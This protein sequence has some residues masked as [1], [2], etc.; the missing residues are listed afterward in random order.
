MIKALCISAWAVAAAASGPATA[1]DYT[2]DEGLA[3][4]SRTQM[5]NPA[6]VDRST[7]TVGSCAVDG[8]E[9]TVNQARLPVS[10]VD[11]RTAYR[12]FTNAIDR[13]TAVE[14]PAAAGGKLYGATRTERYHFEGMRQSNG[15]FALAPASEG[16]CLKATVSVL[17]T[18][19]SDPRVAACFREYDQVVQRHEEEHVEDEIAL[20]K[21]LAADARK[22][23]SATSEGEM[24]LALLDKTIALQAQSKTRSDEL[25]A[26][27]RDGKT[28]EQAVLDDITKAL[29]ACLQSEPFSIDMTARCTEKDAPPSVHGLKA[30]LFMSQDEPGRYS[31]LAQSGVVT[32]NV[33]AVF[34]ARAPATLSILELKTNDA[35]EPVSLVIDAANLPVGVVPFGGVMPHPIS[36]A[37][38]GFG[39][40]QGEA[41]TPQGDAGWRWSVTPSKFVRIDENDESVA[42]AGAFPGQHQNCDFNA[43]MD[44]RVI[45]RV[46]N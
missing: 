34:P 29:N 5:A 42:Y 40:A 4:P 21:A 22:C 16:G 46:A 23:F 10:G 44:F 12:N 6:V 28:E 7:R 45:K 38:F 14:Q 41:I 8:Y 2:I 18:E 15:C 39:G 11:R 36:I 35:D 13:F 25:H 17:K 33:P 27:T 20:V 31:A 19:F 26:R 43:T 24:K 37:L 32:T 1:I 3:F 30:D 9:I